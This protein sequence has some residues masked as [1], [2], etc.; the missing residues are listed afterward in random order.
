MARTGQPDRTAGTRPPGL[1]NKDRKARQESRER[2]AREDKENST[3]SIGNRG[4][5]AGI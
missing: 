2:T 1:D 5:T 4:R 3:S